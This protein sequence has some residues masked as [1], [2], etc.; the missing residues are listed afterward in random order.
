VDLA[1]FRSCGGTQSV[2][3]GSRTLRDMD[4]S[5]KAASP[6]LPTTLR[7]TGH[8]GDRPTKLGSPNLVASLADCVA[9]RV[10]PPRLVGRH[11]RLR[12]LPILGMIVDLGALHLRSPRVRSPI[13]HDWVPWSFDDRWPS[14]WACGPPPQVGC[15]LAPSHEPR[16]AQPRNRRPSRIF[17][18]N[19]SL[20]LA[21][22]RATASILHGTKDRQGALGPARTQLCIPATQAWGTGH[23]S[24]QVRSPDDPSQGWVVSGYAMSDLPWRPDR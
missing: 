1:T 19:P 13:R 14:P 17:T 24:Y 7:E 11:R 16:P 18:R 6:I 9:S 23:A 3:R 12:A 22:P 4:A 8:E 5:T 15:L 21:G 20:E 2:P 10:E